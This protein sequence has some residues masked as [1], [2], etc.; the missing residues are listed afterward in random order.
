[1]QKSRGVAYIVPI[2]IFSITYNITKFFEV[3][4]EP[5][6]ITFKNE[7]YETVGLPFKI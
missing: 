1:M 4:L 6:T 2:V 7:T 5:G 3:A